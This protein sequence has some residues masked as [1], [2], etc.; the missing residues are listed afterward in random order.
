MLRSMR[1][2]GG[3]ELNFG[4]EQPKENIHNPSMLLHM[5]HRLKLRPFEQGDDC[6]GYSF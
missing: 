4:T 1:G 6:I 5:S 3:G 2:G